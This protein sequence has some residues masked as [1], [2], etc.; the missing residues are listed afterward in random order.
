MKGDDSLVPDCRSFEV[1][2]PAGGERYTVEFR[3][4]Q[5][6]ISLRRTDTVDV[7]F[8]VN[9]ASKTVA[10]PHGALETACRNAGQP[11]T[12]E[13]CLRIAAHHLRS[14][15]LA[16]QDVDQEVITLTAERVDELARS[17]I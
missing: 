3:W 6:A 9:G 12:D 17:L 5:T 16:G 13:L 1:V 14:A 11:L 4:L 10:L 15:L 8:L 2:S 7:R